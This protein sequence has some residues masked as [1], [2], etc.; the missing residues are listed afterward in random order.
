M[1][2]SITDRVTAFRDA[3]VFLAIIIILLFRPSGLVKVK[4]VVERV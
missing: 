1:E 3:F 4:A 2:M